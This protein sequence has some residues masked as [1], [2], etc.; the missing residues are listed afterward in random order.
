MFSDLVEIFFNFFIIL[1][2]VVVLLFFIW[3][4]WFLGIV[5][6]MLI[7]LVVSFVE[8]FESFLFLGRILIFEMFFVLIYD[9]KELR[10]NLGFFVK[11]FNCWSIWLF[12]CCVCSLWRCVLIFLVFFLSFVCCWWVSVVFW[13]IK[14]F[15]DFKFVIGCSEILFFF[16]FL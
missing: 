12:S 11:F 13:E 14:E 1:L 15:L 4:V 10:F 6:L 3:F 7:W 2:I 16:F 8:V 5:S 9:F